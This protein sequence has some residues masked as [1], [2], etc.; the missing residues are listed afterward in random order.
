MCAEAA[1]ADENEADDIDE[2]NTTDVWSGMRSAKAEAPPAAAAVIADPTGKT[3]TKRAASTADKHPAK[4]PTKTCPIC[5]DPIGSA[6]HKC[7]FA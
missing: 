6:R 1:V 5:L 3:K 2:A 7:P 4:V